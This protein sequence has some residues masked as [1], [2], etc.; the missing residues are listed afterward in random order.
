MTDQDR[1]RT[2][3]QEGARFLISSDT[4]G[5]SILAFESV[6]ENY[7]WILAWGNHFFQN[8]DVPT[9]VNN[10]QRSRPTQIQLYSNYPN[11][12][13]PSTT[14]TFDVPRAADV[15]ITIFDYLGR[16]LSTIVD[17]RESPGHHSVSFNGLHL[18]SGV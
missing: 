12:F 16:E 11:P 2:H 14:I 1:I 4:I 5:V 7:N 6:S 17:H 13:N 10:I 9:R 15:Q 18:P 8:I 3:L